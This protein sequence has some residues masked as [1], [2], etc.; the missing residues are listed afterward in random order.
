MEVDRMGT[1]A[2]LA[3]EDAVEAN[4]TSPRPR[5]GVTS[6]H[7][8]LGVLLH[9]ECAGG[10]LVQRIQLS[11]EHAIRETRWVLQYGRRQEGA[12]VVDY[13]GVPHSPM[14][15]KIL[16]MCVDDAN[17]VSATYPIGTEHFLTAL[18]QNPESIGGNLLRSFGVTEKQ[19]LDARTQL[20]ERLTVTE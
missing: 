12:Q 15:R 3:W 11:V 14:A 7:L 4:R 20:W 16:D 13:S 5:A 2:R 10:I 1:C 17:T 6:G 9:L 18:I 19:V 8:L